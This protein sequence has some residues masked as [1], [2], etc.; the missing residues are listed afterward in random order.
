MKLHSPLQSEGDELEG[1]WP[2]P[3]ESTTEIPPVTEND[4]MEEEEEEE[5]LPALPEVGEAHKL[6]TQR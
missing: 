3:T 4:P 1:R 2:S 6:N 5:A